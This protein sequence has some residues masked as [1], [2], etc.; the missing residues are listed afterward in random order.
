MMYQTGRNY[1][2]AARIRVGM[3]VVTG[4]TAVWRRVIN[5]HAAEMKT[6]PQ[7]HSIF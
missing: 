4:E 2:G 6:T 7:E 1:D 5:L 3:G